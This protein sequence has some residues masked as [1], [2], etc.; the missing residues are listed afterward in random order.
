MIQETPPATQ[1]NPPVVINPVVFFASYFDVYGNAN[2]NGKNKTIE[3]YDFVVQVEPDLSHEQHQAYYREHLRHYAAMSPP[4]AA[5]TE[6]TVMDLLAAC[7]SPAQIPVFHYAQYGG[8]LRFQVPG[9]RFSGFRFQ[10]LSTGVPGF[11]FQVYP[12][13]T[14]PS[15]PQYPTSGTPDPRYPIPDTRYPCHPPTHPR[16][17]AS[18]TVPCAKRYLQVA[19]WPR[20]A[21][22]IIEEFLG[23][24]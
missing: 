23:L 22:R 14:L 3:D 21:A 18:S 2:C 4:L 1:V 10:A 6:A 7:D 15:V 24:K 12:V 13:T 16:I 9:F 20:E 17:L 19:C 8:I 11:R 5:L